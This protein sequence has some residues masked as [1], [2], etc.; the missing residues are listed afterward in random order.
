MIAKQPVY[1]FTEQQ[2]TARRRSDYR[3]PSRR[4]LNEY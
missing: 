2:H 1:I 3:R 4:H